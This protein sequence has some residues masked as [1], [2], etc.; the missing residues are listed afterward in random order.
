[1]HTI[2]KL[3]CW[4][5]GQSRQYNENKHLTQSFNLFNPT[6]AV[7]HGGRIFRVTQFA[8]RAKHNKWDLRN[9][10][11]IL[12]CIISLT[13]RTIA[14]DLTGE[15]TAF[16]SGCTSYKVVGLS[17]QYCGFDARRGAVHD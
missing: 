2:S 14:A 7:T 10:N 8:S 1:M 16:L 4:N 15:S 17:Q 5:H 11:H 12:N 3:P 6:S 9:L 13:D